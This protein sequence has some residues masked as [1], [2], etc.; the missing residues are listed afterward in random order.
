MPGSKRQLRE[1]VWEL[2]VS[3]GRDSGTGKYKQLSRTYH[4]SAE[5]ADEALRVLAE[6]EAPK[7][8]RA[9]VG[10]SNP[11][12]NHT[13]DESFGR[14]ALGDQV[15]GLAGMKQLIEV[16][17]LEAGECVVG[18]SAD[19]TTANGDGEADDEAAYGWGGA[20]VYQ[21]VQLHRVRKRGEDAT[22]T[23]SD[24]RSVW[25]PRELVEQAQPAL[26]HDCAI[27]IWTL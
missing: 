10:A 14:R 11:E 21:L 24:S 8:R 4:G 2:R 9:T 13:P 18:W 19:R 25:I 22:A 17:P 27:H 5:G 20:A 23:T 26:G 3:L 1:G 7:L 12:A 16:L 6:Q 15:D